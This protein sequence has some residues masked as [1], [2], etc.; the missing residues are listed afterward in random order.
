MQKDV[1][2]NKCNKGIINTIR[3]TYFRFIYKRTDS[4]YKVIYDKY[5]RPYMNSLILNLDFENNEL[6]H[7]LQV[8]NSSLSD[9]F[10][11]DL[12]DV[13]KGE[14][15]YELK[16]IILEEEMYKYYKFHYFTTKLNFYHAL[17]TII[18][19][20]GLFSLYKITEKK[21]YMKYFFGYCRL[22]ILLVIGNMVFILNDSKSKPYLEQML[23]NEIAIYNNL[24]EIN[25]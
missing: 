22:S 5:F 21:T 23:G 9:V 8:K 1:L 16:N 6:D 20:P 24:Y 2:D 19:F 11:K 15:E 25:T 7:I 12:K 18:V 13:P 14:S 4:L 17:L 10:W 3:N